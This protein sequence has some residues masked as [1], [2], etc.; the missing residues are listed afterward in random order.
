MSAAYAIS[1]PG[2]GWFAGRLSNK[3]PLMVIGLIATSVGYLLLGPSQIIPVAPSF[4]I[5]TSGM[6]ILGLA[7]SFAFIPTFESILDTVIERG[8]PDDVVTYSLVSGLWSS[9]NSFG[10]VAGAGM[11]GVFL[12]YYNFKI[13]ANAIALWT[14]VTAL[15]LAVFYI[16]ELACPS[17]CL[18]KSISQTSSSASG[19]TSS[20][21]YVFGEKK[22]LATSRDYIFGA[23][24]I[25]DANLLDQDYDES[26][27]LLGLNEYKKKSKAWRRS[28]L[29]TI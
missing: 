14:F 26:L 25:N 28:F 18:R 6:L 11:G 20:S 4:W 29:L 2:V 3:S 17:S 22:K 13:G 23:N 9:V 10:E 8:A 1:S 27:S 19:S 24:Q 15:V 12:D 16:V 21:D 7:Y 5:S